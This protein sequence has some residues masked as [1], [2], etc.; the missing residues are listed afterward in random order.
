[1]AL[2]PKR[3]TSLS[4]LLKKVPQVIS[5]RKK[6]MHRPGQTGTNN[7]AQQMPD[8]IWSYRRTPLVKPKNF[9]NVINFLF[10]NRLIS[11]LSFFFQFSVTHRLNEF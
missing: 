2:L 1:M 6:S 8:A 5:A 10:C 4:V 9:L 7:V 3:A 11:L